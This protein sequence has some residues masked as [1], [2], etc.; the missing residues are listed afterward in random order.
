MFLFNL[1]LSFLL[2]QAKILI[3]SEN[4]FQPQLLF[5]FVKKVSRTNL[6]CV[7]ALKLFSCGTRTWCC[8]FLIYKELS[9]IFKEKRVT[10]VFLQLNYWLSMNY[11]VS[12]L[13][14]NFSFVNPSYAFILD[15]CV[16]SLIGGLPCYLS[17]LLHQFF[18]LG[19]LLISQ[20][21]IPFTAIFMPLFWMCR[22][23]LHELVRFF[24]VG[25]L[26]I[27]LPPIRFTGIAAALL[28]PCASVLWRNCWFVPH[29][30]IESYLE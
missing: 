1:Q 7:N 8:Y 14:E 19:K 28:F 13:L 20:P 23:N 29:S 26:L 25:K 16:F 22:Y 27:S 11:F 18:V 15:M 5:M 9:S 6:A 2:V 12:F 10:I 21:P 17:H 24:A 4:S 3:P 30:L